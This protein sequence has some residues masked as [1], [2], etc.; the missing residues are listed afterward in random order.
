M[1]WGFHQQFNDDAR[2]DRHTLRSG[3]FVADD[4]TAQIPE[5]WI[6]AWQWYVDLVTAGA[7][8]NQSEMES[9]MLRRGNAFNTATWRWPSA[10]CGTRAAC[11]TTNGVGRRVLGP[12]R[13]ARVRR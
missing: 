8:P 1:Q 7:A 10:I 13:C 6:D 11:A 9:D 12:R 3:T 4:G 2:L 5:Q